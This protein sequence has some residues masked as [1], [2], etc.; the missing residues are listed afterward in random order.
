[1]AVDE[2]HQEGCAGD[3]VGLVPSR[4]CPFPLPRSPEN[5]GRTWVR[6]F[7]WEVIPGRKSQT[8]GGMRPVRRTG[9]GEGVIVRVLP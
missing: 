2:G 5:R 6:M 1:M 9:R 4:F 3:V 7:I 8:A